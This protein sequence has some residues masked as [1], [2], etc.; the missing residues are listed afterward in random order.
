MPE[1]CDVCQGRR[2]IVLPLYPRI[3]YSKLP[4]RELVIDASRKTFPCP[5]CGDAAPVDR[6]LHLGYDSQ[7]PEN[8]RDTPAMEAASRKAIALEMGK[9]LLDAGLI[10]FRTRNRGIEGFTVEGKIAVVSPK[11]CAT[12]EERIAERQMDV[13]KELAAEIQRQIANWGSAYD[14][15]NIGKATAGY[16]IGE[17]VKK[18]V[19]E[20]KPAN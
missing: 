20:R 13:A 1:Y 4:E 17:S 5:Q 12:L 8:E 18:I 9:R 3:D 19:A 15:D 14:R 10:T 2:T 6:V 11:T 7:F 16:L